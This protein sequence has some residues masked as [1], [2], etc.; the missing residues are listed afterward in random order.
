MREE[1][2]PTLTTRPS[3]TAAVP[4]ESGPVPDTP[5]PGALTIN[6]EPTLSEFL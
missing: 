2:S 4:A 6:E 3:L 1:V 5:S